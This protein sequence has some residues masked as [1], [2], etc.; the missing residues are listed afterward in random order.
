MVGSIVFERNCHK[1][2]A[3]SI[4]EIV[5]AGVDAVKEALD[6]DEDE[7]PWYYIDPRL[8]WK[9]ICLHLQ[10]D[11][12]KDEDVRQ[13][14]QLWVRFYKGPWTHEYMVRNN[15]QFVTFL[16]RDHSGL[17]YQQS[18]VPRDIYP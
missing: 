5:K 8:L 3:E 13:A 12:S 11:V 16:C 14:F 2:S 15:D 17:T 18:V 6:H 1:S 10:L 9:V 7:T 4:E